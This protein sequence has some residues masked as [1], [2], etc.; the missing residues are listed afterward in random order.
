MLIGEVVELS[1]VSARMLRHYEA[2][3]L[4]PTTR[5]LS[6]G[7]REYSDADLRRIFH[8]ESL[9]T[10]GMSL[11]QVRSALDDPDSDLGEVVDQLIGETGRRLRRDSELLERLRSVK[12][13]GV[14][15]TDSVLGVTALLTALR[16]TDPGRRQ[17]SALSVAPPVPV[18]QLVRSALREEDPNVAGALS[19]AVLQAGD[20]ALAEV[21]RGLH[22]RDAA[23][24]LRALRILVQSPGSTPELRVALAD[25]DPAVSHLAALELGRRGEEQAVGIL[26]GMI[27]AG[28]RDV[29]AAEA[30]AL[31]PQW[32]AAVI[33]QI[34]AELGNRT[35]PDPARARLTQALAEFPGAGEL[36]ESLTAD[37]NRRVRLT[38]RSILD[39]RA[40]GRRPRG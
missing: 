35:G 38:A 32:E 10:L 15:D 19:W 13:T 30:L 1:G 22:S 7:Y 34:A 11:E 17:L 6:S 39:S 14:G 21:G 12:S 2:R 23:V 26:L 37:D 4:L 36:L 20:A 18:P 31:H 27:P 5:R 25:S 9:R 16:S 29:E 28:H 33:Q 40:P 3:G 8:I 24:R